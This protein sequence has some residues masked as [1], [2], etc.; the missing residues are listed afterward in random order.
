MSKL[1]P[2]I[3]EDMDDVFIS[4]GPNGSIVSIGLANK[5]GRSTLTKV[6]PSLECPS[7]RKLV[8]DLKA[9]CEA[10]QHYRFIHRLRR[11]VGWNI[12]THLRSYLPLAPILSPE[13][14]SKKKEVPA[15]THIRKTKNKDYYLRYL[16]LPI[17]E[18]TLFL[19]HALLHFSSFSSVG[20]VGA[21]AERRT[22]SQYSLLSQ[23]CST[24]WR[25]PNKSLAQTQRHTLAGQ[26]PKWRG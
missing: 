15:Q 17:E 13:K 16:A 11:T 9:A 12:E 23:Y 7:R 21:S 25:L 6:E 19:R 20:T 10:R 8:S 14:C 24:N 2:T 26:N 5:I 18:V 3:I 22:K 4:E 1:K